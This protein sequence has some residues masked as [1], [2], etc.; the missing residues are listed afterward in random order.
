[1][2]APAAIAEFVE[3]F[4]EF[5]VIAEDRKSTT[6]E[7]NYRLYAEHD[8]ILL[9]EDYRLEIVVPSDYPLTIP[10]VFETSGRI[11]P[12]YEHKYEN[13][14]L[15]LGIDGEIASSLS[16]DSSLADFLEGYVRDALYSAKFFSRYGR[17]PFGDREHGSAGI[18]AYYAE[19]FGVKSEEALGILECIAV[20]KYRGHLECPCGSGLKGRDCHGKAIIA[21]IQDPARRRAAAA[22]FERVA[23]ERKIM[24]MAAANRRAIMLS[25]SQ[26]HIERIRRPSAKG[27]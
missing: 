9:S 1:M 18:L 20:G 25:L 15:C 2:T 21:A 22:D 16:S 7:G 26:S 12:D 3:S 24:R 10:T 8:G 6:L 14:A 11:P 4:P 5:A 27:N 17:Y 23:I 13:G 19:A